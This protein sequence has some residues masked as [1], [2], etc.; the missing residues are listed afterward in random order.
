M[1]GFHTATV[2]ALEIPL[3]K[4]ISP[5]L[6]E[7]NTR[8]DIKRWWEV[9]DRTTGEIVPVD[10]WDYNAETG[11]VVLPA[12]D[13]FHEYTVAFLAYLIWD[14]VHMYN[15]VTNNW[16]ITRKVFPPG[17]TFRFFCFQIVPARRNPGGR[18]SAPV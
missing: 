3:M 9:V 10:A 7:V 5:E 6:M 8:D 14:P 13:A 18:L 15:A 16:Q 12:P 2:G 4:G 17:K 1:T 11:C